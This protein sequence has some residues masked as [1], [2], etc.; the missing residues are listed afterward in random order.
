MHSV[1]F[2]KCKEGCRKDRRNTMHVYRWT[3]KSRQVENQHYSWLLP[4]LITCE[5][6]MELASEGFYFSN[7]TWT[8]TGI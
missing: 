1:R 7:F 5:D 4:A 2:G 3:C 8:I 6:G